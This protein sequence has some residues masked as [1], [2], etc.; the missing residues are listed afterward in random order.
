MAEILY[1]TVIV[2]TRFRGADALAAIRLMRQ[3]NPVRL[4]REPHNPFDVWAV[5]CYYRGV[6][7]GYIPRQANERI[8]QAIDRGAVVS[9]VIETPPVVTPSGHITIEPK[10]RIQ[11]AE[12]QL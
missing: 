9:A 10:L 1:Q 5:A 12:P 3:H 7:V 6:H 11:V 2:G 4:E 8:A